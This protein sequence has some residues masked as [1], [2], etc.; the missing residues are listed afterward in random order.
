[1]VY[2]L[3]AAVI[4]LVY[5]FYVLYGGVYDNLS[6]ARIGC[7]YNFLYLQPLSGE[8][9]R[10]YVKVLNIRTLDKEDID[11]LN[12]FSLYR[13]YDNVFH[14]TKTLVT[15]EMKDGSIRNFYAERASDC[16]RLMIH[17]L[18]N[19]LRFS[20]VSPCPVRV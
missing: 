16:K 3:I 8:Y 7:V 13:R 15:C 14:R 6:N 11:S 18:I 1:M 20:L 12:C 2:Y 9:Q 10:Y 17:T 5:F 4:F 19:R